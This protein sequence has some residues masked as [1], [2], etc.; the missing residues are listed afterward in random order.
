MRSLCVCLELAI[1]NALLHSLE[2]PTTKALFPNRDSSSATISL[3]S[4]LKKANWSSVACVS[5]VLRNILRHLKQD[6]DE[7]LLE[8]YLTSISYCLPNLPWNSLDQLH[9]DQNCEA[10]KI[11]SGKFY[12]RVGQLVSTLMFCGTLVQMFCSLVNSSGWM[13]PTGVTLNT[14]P[15]ICE[16]SSLIPRLLAWCHADRNNMGVPEYFRHKMLVSISFSCSLNGFQSLMIFVLC[17][18]FFP[19]WN[20]I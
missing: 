9:C 17:T 19:C 5:R 4:K 7:Q 15:V 18:F 1:S 2:H 20:Y 12:S 11:S 10:V 6:L 8:A 3:T 16:I 13:V 14:H